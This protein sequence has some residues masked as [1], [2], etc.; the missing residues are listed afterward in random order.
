MAEVIPAILE[1]DF[2]EIEKKIRLVEG[3]TEWVQ[4]DIADGILVPNTTFSDPQPFKNLKTKLK[5]EAHLMV[6]E[7]V[8]YIKPFF[9]AG[10]RRFYAHIESGQAE[11]YIAECFKYD[12]QVGL[13]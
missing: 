8:A 6:K 11:E 9:E 7:P 4:I 5:L 1:K 10:F 13:A 2:K 3:L 12:C